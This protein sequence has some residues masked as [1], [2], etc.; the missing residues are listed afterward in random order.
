MSLQVKLKSRPSRNLSLALLRDAQISAIRF[1]ADVVALNSTDSLP[2]PIGFE[3]DKEEESLPM[4]QDLL[5]RL[6]EIKGL[7]TPDT[8]YLT[9]RICSADDHRATL[10]EKAAG[11]WTLDAAEVAAFRDYMDAVEA[12]VN[13]TGIMVGSKLIRWKK[14]LLNDVENPQALR[15]AYIRSSAFE[16]PDSRD[17]TYIRYEININ[18]ES[19]PETVTRFGRV[20]CFASYTT[21]SS[22]KHLMAYIQDIPVQFENVGMSGCHR[23]YST[24]DPMPKEQEIQRLFFINADNISALLGLII[25]EGAGYFIEKDTCFVC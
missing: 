5:R 4:L 3:A 13:P 25:V 23:L 8:E 22:N 24:V 14:C 2:L 9:G 17:S 6:A 18:S 21:T 11:L 16:K 12:D 19:G 7:E 1:A 10:H 15:R 20:H